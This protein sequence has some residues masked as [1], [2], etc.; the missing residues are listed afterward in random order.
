MP[1]KRT[2]RSIHA[3]NAPRQSMPPSNW[4]VRT[5][6]DQK[7]VTTTTTSSTTLRTW[8][9]FHPTPR[10]AGRPLLRFCSS[11]LATLSRFATIGGRLTGRRSLSTKLVSTQNTPWK[12]WKRKENRAVG[13]PSV[14]PTVS[15]F[16]SCNI[17]S[18]LV[19]S[20]F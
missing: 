12:K 5:C 7:S 10:Y 2:K 11:S 1:T 18:C 15:P 9:K 13:M 3:S 8:K 4:F 16:E 20:L 17:R 19:S 6:H 14:G